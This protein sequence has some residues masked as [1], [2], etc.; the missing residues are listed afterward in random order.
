MRYAEV[1]GR[2]DGHVTFAMRCSACGVNLHRFAADIGACRMR[3]CPKCGHFLQRRSP[4][5]RDEDIVRMLNNQH[6]VIA[7]APRNCDKYA[8]VKD[9]KTAWFN[10]KMSCPTPPGGWS[11]GDL[12]EWFFAKAEKGGGRAVIWP[13][14]IGDV[15]KID[16]VRMHVG[17]IRTSFAGTFYE[18]WWIV[19]GTLYETEF[20]EKEIRFLIESGG[21]SV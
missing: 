2:S 9:A 12:L 4:L 19:N 11:D 10:Y 15:I 1:I 7:E 5:V 17:A 20:H 13:L 21:G 8:N 16:G 3:Y 14:E 6:T 18:L